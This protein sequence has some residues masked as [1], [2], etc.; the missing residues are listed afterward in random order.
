MVDVRARARAGAAVAGAVAVLAT[1][2]ATAGGGGAAGAAPVDQPL[3]CDTTADRT[4]QVSGTAP[5]TVAAGATMAVEVLPPA[6]Y[7][8]GFGME[9]ITYA[10]A[11]P[12]GTS[13]VNGSIGVSGPAQVTRSGAAPSTVPAVARVIEGGVRIAVEPRIPAN[14]S[15]AFPRLRFQLRA[16]GAPGADISVRMH[17]T[18]AHTFFSIDDATCATAGARPALT[19]TRIVPAANPSTS[20]T[21]PSNTTPTSTTTTAPPPTTSTETVALGACAELT[22]VVPEHAVSVQATVVG[23]AGGA[24][25]RVGGGTSGPGGAGA[26]VAATLPVTPGTTMSLVSGCVPNSTWADGYA[27]GG[28]GAPG[29]NVMG[30]GEDHVA[31]HGGGASAVCLGQVCRTFNASGGEPAPVVVAG[32][33]GGG[34]GSRCTAP[35][36]GAGGEAGTGS[37]TTVGGGTAAAGGPGAAGQD[38]AAGTGGPAAASGSPHG[39]EGRSTTWGSG[40]VNSG[41]GGGGAGYRG[42]GGGGGDE[43]ETLEQPCVSG[44]GG[45][46]GS[47]WVASGATGVTFA[48]ATTA[49]AITLVFTIVTPGV[50]PLDV[51]PFA[52]VEDFVDQQHV[53]L[54]GRVPTASELQ[55]A[56]A[57][58]RNRTTTPEDLV[59]GL[60]STDS[61]AP[62]A[63]I[64]RLYLAYFGRPP[65]TAGLTYWLGQLAGGKSVHTA[66]NQF[67]STPE[68]RQL[69]GSLT[70]RQFVDL[71]YQNVL[72][73]PGEPDG[74]AYWTA[75]LDGGRLKRGTVMTQFSEAI[76]NR[77]AKAAHVGVVRLY[78]E[79]LGNTP[80]RAYL[81]A[82]VAGGAST[83]VV[84]RRVVDDIRHSSAYARRIDAAR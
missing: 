84:W 41:G 34:G 23:A 66:S 37:V 35:L 14:S 43:I 1:L 50:A 10:V 54:L 46:A 39:A 27:V 25:G 31:G 74:V 64:T 29:Y 80:G 18:L 36:G 59:I 40:G 55:Q 26:R 32:G 21:A 68:F 67:V 49:S 33:G 47:S 73:R 61:R 69:Y 65:E 6:T 83:Q 77:T 71:V 11:L 24:G 19:T 38:G 4:I 8:A 78:L 16:T 30:S 57:A 15:V 48:K 62:D 56:A 70:N 53:D 60:L 58:L 12:A 7:T 79:M 17:P 75:E 22:T 3:D 45:G 28:R 52:T 2:L 51:A 76:E 9:D 72:G 44:G 42:G 63:Q 82:A 5:G 81:T 20:S 13:L